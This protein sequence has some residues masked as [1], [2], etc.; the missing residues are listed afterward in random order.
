MPLDDDRMV[1][2]IEEMALTVTKYERGRIY[3]KM[4]TF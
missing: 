3:G 1:V 2:G 4:K